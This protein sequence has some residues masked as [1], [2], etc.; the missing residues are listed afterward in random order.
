MKDNKNSSQKEPTKSDITI[1]KHKI[2]E[3]SKK[4]MKNN[5]LAKN[6]SCNNEKNENFVVNKELQLRKTYIKNNSSETELIRLQKK[7]IYNSIQKNSE[8]YGT[9]SEK[10]ETSKICELSTNKIMIRSTEKKFFECSKEGKN[11]EQ[12]KEANS[13][14]EEDNS[15]E[16]ENKIN[17]KRK[18]SKL[19]KKEK[20]ENESN[21]KLEDEKKQKIKTN[22]KIIEGKDKYEKKLENKIYEDKNYYKFYGN[23]SMDDFI[24]NEYLLKNKNIKRRY[25]ENNK[26]KYYIVYILYFYYFIIIKIFSSQFIKCCHR[27]KELSSSYINLKIKP[28]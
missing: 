28:I 26:N 24:E 10:I 3:K 18:D 7:R 19:N 1:D 8:T 21:I 2:K 20:Y 12:K 16:K 13:N 6:S 11:K 23:Y 22:K 5:A 4:S 14:L 25:K 27:K 15:Q 17:Y 9:D